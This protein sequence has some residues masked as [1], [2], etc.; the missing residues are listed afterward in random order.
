MG[1]DPADDRDLLEE[2]RL[3][4]A[5]GLAWHEP[6]HSTLLLEFVHRELGDNVNAGAV[7]YVIACARVVID[8]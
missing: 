2:D 3:R 6:L 5:I 8:E 4:L 7:E 1:D